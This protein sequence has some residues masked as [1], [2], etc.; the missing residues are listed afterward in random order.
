MSLTA[1]FHIHM[2]YFLEGIKC[3]VV[4]EIHFAVFSALKTSFFPLAL[5]ILCRQS[6]MHIFL[7]PSSLSQIA[8][9]FLSFSEEGEK[10]KRKKLQV[11]LRSGVKAFLAL[12]PVLCSLSTFLWAGVK[13][14]SLY[15]TYKTWYCNSPKEEYLFSY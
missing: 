9:L 4:P 14:V 15:K 3:T 10:W 5:P 2:D 12:H 7:F 13:I 1:L 11:L 6:G 8:L